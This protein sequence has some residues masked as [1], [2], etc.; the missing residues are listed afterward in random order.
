MRLSQLRPM[1]HWLPALGLAVMGGLL[2]ATSQADS[3]TSVQ[4]GPRPF[5][6]VE[7]MAPGS[8]KSQLQA[9]AADRDTYRKSDFSIG[10]RG[11]P[12]QFP[13]HTKESY[14]A[15]ARMGA[16][17]VECDVTFTKDKELVCRHAQNDLHTTTNILATPLAAKC[18]TPFTPATFD[19]NGE[20]TAP[21]NAE[22]RASDVTLAEFRTLRGKMDA[23]NP[24]ARAMS[25]S[26][27]Q[28]PTARAPISTRV[29]PAGHSSPTRKA[30]S[31]S[32]SWASR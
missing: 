9:C 16:G 4:L 32:R 26:T 13:E 7:D 12:L 10:H 31:F 24:R 8:L 3:G 20:V 27:W 15:A 2:P 29:R 19:A 21:A 14:E 22:C 23:F 28:A 5:F 11:A 18:T 6:L 17:I 1:S 30:S 25:R